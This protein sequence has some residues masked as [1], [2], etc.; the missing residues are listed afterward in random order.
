MTLNSDT[1]ICSC[2]NNHKLS[3]HAKINLDMGNSI[4]FTCN[5]KKQFK[6]SI[7]NEKLKLAVI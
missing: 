4:K 6:V 5:C 2:G 3:A 7:E 1:I